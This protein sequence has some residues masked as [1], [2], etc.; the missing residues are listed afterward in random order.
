MN[1]K[2]YRGRSRV[3]QR[4]ETSSLATAII[5]NLK[6]G[7]QPTPQQDIQRHRELTW[8]ADLVLA[9]VLASWV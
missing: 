4:S 9:E 1:F 7:V 3:R 2:F 8:R 5:E 6:C